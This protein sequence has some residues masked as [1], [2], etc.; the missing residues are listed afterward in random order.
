MIYQQLGQIAV[1]GA[2]VLTAASLEGCAGRPAPRPVAPETRVSS[3]LE[4]L[5]NLKPFNPESCSYTI[6]R[7]SRPSR[8]PSPADVLVE[9]KG[10]ATLS[11]SGFTEIRS[12][13]RWKRI[14]RN[15]IPPSLL[16]LVPTGDALASEEFNDGF[17]T[18]PMAYVHGF[19][20]ILDN[21]PRR[22]YFLARD[23]DH[24]LK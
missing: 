1:V 7:S 19:V 8:L 20:V 18:N 4:K 13:F 14:A 23:I 12:S 17:S 24:P 3:L 21:D 22:I 9:L 2:A 15:D 6:E 16:P 5:P 10:A 11:E